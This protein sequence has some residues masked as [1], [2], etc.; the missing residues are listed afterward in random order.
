MSLEPSPLCQVVLGMSKAV[1]IVVRGKLIESESRNV[2][3]IATQKQW[4][5]RLRVSVEEIAFSSKRVVG[6]K[7]LLEDLAPGTELN[8]VCNEER[9]RALMGEAPENGTS[10]EFC[11]SYAGTR[12]I[13]LRS[14]TILS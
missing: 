3:K 4:M 11:G 14:A 5:H 10:V 2:S 12:V 13:A 7:Q 1:E 9:M 6:R 8:F